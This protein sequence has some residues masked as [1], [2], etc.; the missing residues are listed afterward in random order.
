MGVSKEM[1]SNFWN[2]P[3]CRRI[4]TE[5]TM[6]THN[7]ECEY[8]LQPS[9]FLDIVLFWIVRIYFL[10][11]S[12]TVI[13]YRQ[14]LL[15]RQL[16]TSTTV[17]VNRQPLFRA[18]IFT[19]ASW[20]TYSDTAKH[21]IQYFFFMYNMGACSEMNLSKWEP[22]LNRKIFI[23]LPQSWSKS[24]VFCRFPQSM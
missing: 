23:R 12:S 5:T 20:V 14:P 1:S 3:R 24:Y 17:T 13:I 22:N 15:P 16:S 19:R 11:T 9:F 6:P 21:S 18:P 8:A 7:C 4:Y 10:N 2:I